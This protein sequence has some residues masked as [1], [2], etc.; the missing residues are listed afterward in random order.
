RWTGNLGIVFL[1]TALVYWLLPVTAVV[2][3]QLGQARGWGLLN[4]FPLPQAPALLLSVM[5]MDLAIY[6]QHV[7]FHAVPILWRIHR[8]H[9]VDLDF[10]VTTGLR[11]HPI[12]IA[13]SML[14]KLAVVAFL[15]PPPA[16][17]LAFE[18]LLNGTSMFSHGNIRIPQSLE[19]TLRLL[20]VTPDMHRVH[21]S[22][23]VRETNSNFGFNLPWWDRMFGTYRSRPASGHEEMII[24][25]SDFRDRR[26]W[27]LPWMLAIPF[28]GEA[29]IYPFAGRTDPGGLP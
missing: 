13:L 5:A 29:G 16:A 9:H 12:E 26:S 3:A 11:F 21:H 2:L 7:M 17:V 6:L 20:V 15:G 4:N 1:N 23:L 19:R 14:I 24:G 28:I 25:I 27:S 10:D 8:V 18:I 22:I